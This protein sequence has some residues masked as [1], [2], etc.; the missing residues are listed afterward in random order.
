MPCSVITRHFESCAQAGCTPANAR[1]KKK[2]IRSRFM[3]FPW[4]MCSEGR[5]KKRTVSL[6]Q[7]LPRIPYN[8]LF[9]HKLNRVFSSTAFALTAVRGIYR[10]S[11][12]RQTICSSQASSA[13]LEY[14]ELWDD[15]LLYYYSYDSSEIC[16]VINE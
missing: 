9:S 3:W 5:Q 14:G 13:N 7:P 6:C 15:S 4:S 10:D 2:T 8:G 1:D 16:T 11:K 12:N